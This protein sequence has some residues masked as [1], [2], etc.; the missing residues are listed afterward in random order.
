MPST[1]SALSKEY[2]WWPVFT[3][4]DLTSATAEVALMPFDTDPDVGDWALATLLPEPTPDPE[5]PEVPDWW[6]RIIIGP[7]GDITKPAGDWQEWVAITDNPE[8]PVRK[9]GILELT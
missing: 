9:P 3:P 5:D 8:R 6:V 2:R 7:G 4:N 1:M